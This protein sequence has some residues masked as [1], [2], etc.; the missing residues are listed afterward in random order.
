MRSFFVKNFFEQQSYQWG[1]RGQMIQKKKYVLEK[2]FFF[3]CFV[4]F[5]KIEWF[6]K[7][8]QWVY[9]RMMIKI[10]KVRKKYKIGVF[11][12][13]SFE[14]HCYQWEYRVL[15]LKKEKNFS[16]YFFISYRELI[17]WKK[18]FDWF[19]KTYYTGYSGML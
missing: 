19:G 2:T 10:I 4:P 1:Y 3:H 13:K 6:G 9:T 12:K 5:K 11:S 18:L 17:S 16:E 15:L 7:I 14:K 8:R